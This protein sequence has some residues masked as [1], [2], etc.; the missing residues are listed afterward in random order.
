MAVSHYCQGKLYIN[1]Y[2]KVVIDAIRTSPHPTKYT[3]HLSYES[4]SCSLGKL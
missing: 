4:L 3:R 2:Y 1:D